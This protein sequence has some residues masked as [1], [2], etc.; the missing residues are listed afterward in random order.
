V[1]EL[2][3]LNFNIIES[4]VGGTDQDKAGWLKR[5]NFHLEIDENKRGKY[6][7]EVEQW[8]K[9]VTPSTEVLLNMLAN[10]I[11]KNA[12][13]L[14][15]PYYIQVFNLQMTTEM[16]YPISCHFFIRPFATHFQD[17]YF[18]DPKAE[19]FKWWTGK[20]LDHGL[21]EF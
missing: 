8:L 10:V 5:L 1:T 16:I 18:F 19:E 3:D 9:F 7:I 21:F 20:S 13:F 6:V 15:A 17:F 4:P 2:L 11:E 14:S 12:V